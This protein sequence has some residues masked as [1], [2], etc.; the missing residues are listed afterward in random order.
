[1][2]GFFLS[3]ENILTNFREL[4]NTPWGNVLFMMDVNGGASSSLQY[5][6]IINKI[7]SVLHNGFD[8]KDAMV[9]VTSIVKVGWRNRSRKI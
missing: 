1:M 8:F 7:S 5:L 3:F 2:A 4:G 6:R 9:F